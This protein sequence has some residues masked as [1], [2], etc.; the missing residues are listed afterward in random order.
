[1]RRRRFVITLRKRVFAGFAAVLALLIVLAVVMQRG[2][3]SVRGGDPRASRMSCS[4]M[5]QS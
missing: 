3:G 1:M 4:C 2:A 5:K